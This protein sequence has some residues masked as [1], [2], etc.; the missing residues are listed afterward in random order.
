MWTAKCSYVKELYE[1]LKYAQAM[2]EM[3]NNTLRHPILGNTTYACMQPS[4]WRGTHVGTGRYTSER[5]VYSHPD[6]TPCSSLGF[7]TVG[8]ATT[9]FTPR[10]L[11]EPRHNA[12][13]S[14]LTNHRFQNA[15]ARLEGRLFEW[16]YLY[17][18]KPPEDSWIW[19]YYKDYQT[20][21]EEYFRECKAVADA[22]RTVLTNAGIT[23]PDK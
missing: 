15:F 10:L 3:Y 13:Q 23:V 21:T 7:V 17:G 6:V 20:G 11:R 9:D 16:D 1:P 4:T 18:K 8:K 19:N 14:S 22:T 2:E 5:W 12:H